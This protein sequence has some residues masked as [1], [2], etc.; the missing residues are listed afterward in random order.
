M[1]IKTSNI[2]NSQFEKKKEKREYKI[3]EER[4]LYIQK[5]ER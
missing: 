5:K 1:S 3:K 4:K 2:V